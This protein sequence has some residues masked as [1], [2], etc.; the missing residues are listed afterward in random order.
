MKQCASRNAENKPMENDISKSGVVA[1]TGL[2]E[3]KSNPS[4][5]SGINGLMRSASGKSHQ[6][7]FPALILHRCPTFYPQ[8]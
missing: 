5:D 2:A 6:S 4:V 7:P 1:E 8:S 3:K